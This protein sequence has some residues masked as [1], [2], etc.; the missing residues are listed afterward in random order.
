MRNAALVVRWPA[1]LVSRIGAAREPLIMRVRS[2]V[3]LVFLCPTIQIA[4]GTPVDP[5][6]FSESVYVS[7][8]NLGDLTGIDWAP[9]GSGR[10]FV[11]RKGEFSTAI[12][13]VRI[14]QNGAV[15]STPFA[16]MTVHPFAECGLIGMCFDPDFLN[17]HYVY[18]FFT[19]PAPEQRIVRY[20]DINN[21]G[22]NPT[23][24]VA[25]LPTRNDI[26]NGG[27]I[28]FGNDG[29]LYWAIGELGNGSGANADLTSLASKIGRATRTGAVPNDNP[30]ID[31]A[32][33][34]NDYIWA[35]GF[36]NPYTFTFQRTTGQLWCNTVGDSWEQTFLPFRGSHSGWN[37]Y[38]NNQPT[39]FLPPVITYRT[40][41]PESR[42]I[43]A[44][45][46][47]RL[48]GI[49]TFT[50]A[51]PH[52]FR[53]GAR[54]T[55]ADV[56]DASFNGQFDVAAVLPGSPDAQI[57]TR[58][59]VEQVGPDRTSSGGTVTTQNIGGA[60]LGGCFYDSTA[61]PAA[62]RGNF[63]FGDFNT[64]RIMRVELDAMNLPKHTEEFVNNIGA[65]ID[66]TTGPD[67][68]LYY[69]DLLGTIRRLA[70]TSTA[71]N[72]IVQPTAFN[73]VE[74]GSSVFT[75]RL[76]SAPAANVI[77]TTTRLSGDVDLSINSGA[78]LT[79][80]PGNYNVPQ[81]I[82]IAAAEDAD[83]DNDSA[84]F[85]VLAPG[86]ATYDVNVNGIDN[87]DPQ[88]VISA[89]SLIVNEGGFNTFTVRL[90]NLPLVDVSVLVGR[91]GSTDVAVSAGA[92]LTFTPLS[93]ATPQPVIISA[94]EDSDN[95]NDTA[96]I[97]VLMAGQPLRNIPVTVIDNDPL[98]PAF[99]S[100]PI[101]TAV[102][103]A[104]YSY[105]ANANGN[106]IPTFALTTAP[107]GMG[108]DLATG[109][110][111]WTPINTGT[112]PVTIQA[113]NGVLPNATQSFN[114]TVK[115]DSPPTGVLTRPQPGDVESGTNAEFFGDGIDD[116]ST[117][118]AEFFIDGVL[119]YTDINNNNHFHY[120]GAHHLFDTTQFTHGSHIAGFHV[121]DT[122]GQTNRKN[123]RFTIGSGGASPPTPL[124]AISRKVHG[125]AGTFD[126][127]L[128][129]TGNPGIE[130]RSGGDTGD[131]Q[132][133]ITFANPVTVNGNFQADVVAGTGSVGISGVANGGVVT[134]N[135]AV[136]TVP[137]TNVAN[138][139]RIAI[140][141]FDVHQGANAG[142]VT[143]PI[144]FLVGDSIGNR[145][146]NASDV[147]QVKSGLGQIVNG[148]NFRRDVTANGAINS[149]DITLVKSKSGT[150]IAQ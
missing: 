96:T 105:D 79:F 103:G 13:E 123:V 131:Y 109:V 28:G 35:R 139:Q 77:V 24:I 46:A 57:S 43:T 3:Y 82:T 125:Q 141:L 72:L 56:S 88:L 19:A 140:T 27:A 12:A 116:V 52:P 8:P 59:T 124:S 92:S 119:R 74:G 114:I 2:L 104:G 37:T 84:V 76:A 132:V 122:K 73:V 117:V 9:D 101:L 15:L 62:F 7:S 1:S 78:L 23:V 134:V 89:S 128:P 70:T 66:M 47:V 53:K 85:R 39:G 44:N 10:L 75:V 65:H 64:G 142:D 50:T 106:P 20:T 4:T 16:T 49:V 18:F 34:N 5:A 26:H 148:S 113:S 14:V 135:G 147:S 58:F 102:Q 55:I 40:N 137:L 31:G 144:D 41:N 98:A 93:Y 100:N 29:K 133:V 97:I 146:V 54:V 83:V 127:H 145:V 33:P 94:S 138:A 38:E 112:F 11:I 67:G 130:C 32:G 150:G 61:F 126:I 86:I 63:F 111:N 136:V 6:S 22:T 81:L 118:K 87:D 149:S 143:I 25:G 129:L 99:A 91:T 121:T 120:G 48:A 42:T 45:G 60:I 17:N 21:V 90:A 69:A 71:Q 36:R 108:A 30:F 68:A 95:V 115:I 80:T 110:I 107:A 51:A